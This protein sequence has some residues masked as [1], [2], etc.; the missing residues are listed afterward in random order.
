MGHYTRECVFIAEH[1]LKNKEN[2]VATVRKFHTKYDRN[3]DLTL[4]TVKRVVENPGRLDQFVMLNPGNSQT[5]RSNGN[6]EAVCK[7]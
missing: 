4:P 6:I 5:S 7:Y 3:I 1:Y 2:L